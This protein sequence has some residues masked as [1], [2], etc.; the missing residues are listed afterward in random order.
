VKALTLHQPWASAIALGVKKH[1]TRSWAPPAAMIG[2]RIAIHAGRGSTLSRNGLVIW[3]EEAA[4]WGHSGWLVEAGAWDPV[5]AA[6]T[7]DGLP[8]GV[9]LCTA[10]VR[11]VIRTEVAEKEVGDLDYELGDYSHGRYAWR[12]TQVRRLAEPVPLRGMQGLFSVTTEMA[13]EI[14]RQESG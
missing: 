3:L 12:L 2:Q 8:R 1:E 14:T 9:V 7:P 11:E 13:R 10:V 6:A 4:L 5:Q